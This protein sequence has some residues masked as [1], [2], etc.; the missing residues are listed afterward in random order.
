M[1]DRCS[2][3]QVMYGVGVET[4]GAILDELSRLVDSGVIRSHMHDC[5]S[6]KEY[7]K[8]FATLEARKT[9]GKVNSHCIEKHQCFHARRSPLIE[10]R[11]VIVACSLCVQFVMVIDENRA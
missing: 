5:V 7:N 3:L 10:S 8:A 9:I 11:A 2:L 6:W 1:I 4:Q